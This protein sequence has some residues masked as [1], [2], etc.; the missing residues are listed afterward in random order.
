MRTL[1]STVTFIT[2]C[3]FTGSDYIQEEVS[4]VIVLFTMKTCQHIVKKIILH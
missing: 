4:W 3:P 2:S 1:K